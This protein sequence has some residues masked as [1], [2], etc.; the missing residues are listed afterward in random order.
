[1]KIIL[2]GKD[3]NHE[4]PPCSMNFHFMPLQETLDYGPSLTIQNPVSFKKQTTAY[5]L[6]C[7]RNMTLPLSCWR[8]TNSIN[9]DSKAFL[10]LVGPIDAIDATATPLILGWICEA[11]KFALPYAAPNLTKRETTWHGEVSLSLQIPCWTTTCCILS[12]WT[13]RSKE[14]DK[15]VYLCSPSKEVASSCATRTGRKKKRKK[16]KCRYYWYCH[17]VTLNHLW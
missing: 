11:L 15:S 10:Q 13:Q 6:R 3:Q 14:I 8:L 2:I 7:P 17:S 5:D 12:K 9:C 16:D 4:W 1:M